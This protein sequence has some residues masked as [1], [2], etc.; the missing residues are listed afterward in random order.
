MVITKNCVIG[1]LLTKNDP[2]FTRAK[3]SLL[4]FHVSNLPDTYW[5]VF[6]SSMATSFF[7]LTTQGLHSILY[8]FFPINHGETS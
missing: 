8:T 6:W 3:A 5:S 4:N 2:I 7:D 1:T